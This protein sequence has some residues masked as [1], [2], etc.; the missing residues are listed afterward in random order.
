MFISKTLLSMET[1]KR[2]YL[3]PVQTVTFTDVTTFIFFAWSPYAIR[4][5][6]YQSCAIPVSLN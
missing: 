6:S 1:I 5:L 4:Y 2:R 3:F